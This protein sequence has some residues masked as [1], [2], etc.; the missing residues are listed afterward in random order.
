MLSS[1]SWASPAIVAWTG[2]CVPIATFLA[3]GA[4]LTVLPDIASDIQLC[5][6]ILAGAIVGLAFTITWLLRIDRIGWRSVPAVAAGLLINGYVAGGTLIALL[7]LLK[8][9]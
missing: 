5:V 9:P 2:A 7:A 4:A 6:L 1:N 3:L 8:H